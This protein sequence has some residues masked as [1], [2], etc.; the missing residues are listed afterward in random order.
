MV[1]LPDNI[2]VL[3]Q[4]KEGTLDAGL[5]DSLAAFYFIRSSHERYFILHDSLSEEE[6]A[7]GF[8]KEDKEL[9]NR[10]QKILR[11]MKADGTLGK[12]SQKWF[13]SDIIIVK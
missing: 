6:L 1:S 2:T 8:R 3:Q 10:I 7:M 9:R 11:E 13:E 5:V 12:I 4:L